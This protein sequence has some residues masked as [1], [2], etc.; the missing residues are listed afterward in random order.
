MDANLFHLIWGNSTIL[1]KPQMAPI[2]S[3][4]GAYLSSR[5]TS[6]QH[7]PPTENVMSTST[8]LHIVPWKAGMNLPLNKK[9]KRAGKGQTYN[10][11]RRGMIASFRVRQ[12]EDKEHEKRLPEKKLPHRVR[13]PN[14][15]ILNRAL[16]ECCRSCCAG[17]RFGVK[18]KVIVE[19][20]LRFLSGR[21]VQLTQW[22]TALFSYGFQ[23]GEDGYRR[24]TVAAISWI[25]FE[26]IAV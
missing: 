24:W 13:R 17:I 21:F 12:V 19:V 1:P 4:E 18:L 25:L 8:D 23:S 11:T 14:I 7:I 3:C 16:V 20:T 5:D 9:I 10:S 6:S 2:C 15:S 26:T 22:S